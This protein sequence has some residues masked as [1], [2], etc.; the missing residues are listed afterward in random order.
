M[1]I[2]ENGHNI[3]YNKKSQKQTARMAPTC[4]E[5]ADGYMG[6]KKDRKARVTTFMNEE[7]L[8][9]GEWVG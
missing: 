7:N 4:G 3:L 1:N 9:P 5:D 2:A 8:K 6:T